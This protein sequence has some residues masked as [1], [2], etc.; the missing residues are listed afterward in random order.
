MS[1]MNEVIPALRSSRI[2]A[3]TRQ[4]SNSI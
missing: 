1:V 3:K 4:R 2:T